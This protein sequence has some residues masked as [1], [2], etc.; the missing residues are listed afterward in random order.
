[1]KRCPKCN[2]T[3]P[4]ENQ[5]FC[6]FDGG[7][8]ISSATFDPN[9]T[10]RATAADVETYTQETTKESATSR[11]L[12]TVISAVPPQPPSQP[13]NQPPDIDPNETMMASAPT[14]VFPRN[15]G[16]TNYPTSTNL[17]PPPRPSV[18]LG[19]VTASTPLPPRPRQSTPLPAK[20]KSK[21]PWVLAALFVL[22][23]LGGGALAAVFFVVVKPRLEHLREP[24]VAEAPKTTSTE[25]TNKNASSEKKVEPVVEDTFV[26]PP[27]AAKFENSGDKL[28]GKLAEH[29]LDFHFYYP[30]SWQSDPN[31]GVAGASNFA[32]VFKT[33]K[34]GTE[35]YTPESVAISWYNSTG[36][37]DGDVSVF[38][39]RVESLSAQLA[40]SL[41]NYKKVS[42]GPTLVNSLKSY[43]FH[44]T[45]VSKQEGQQDLPYWGR[46]IFIPPGKENEKSGVTIIMLA[47]G[48]ATGIKNEDDVGAKGEMQLIL[49]SFRFGKKE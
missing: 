25:E 42:E 37:Y 48:Q 7:L 20:K 34:E 17:Q 2:R 41:P 38:P 31:A 4:D 16:P 3:F 46:A 26:P 36:T 8:L 43:D 5:K 49:D 12:P 29:Y 21:L 30:G 1:M 9:M 35:E 28:D 13:P 45:G 47:T 27:G 15:T 23:L 33:V 6:T 44:F 18:P 19:A 40:K 10:I 14:A 24:V 32:R 39:S 22:F 11:D